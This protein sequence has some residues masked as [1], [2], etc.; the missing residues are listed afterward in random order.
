MSWGN[1]KTA[2]SLGIV[3]LA[4]MM[5]SVYVAFIAEEGNPLAERGYAK[6]AFDNAGNLRVG[7]QVRINQ[8]QVGRVDAIDLDGDRA[9]VTMQLGDGHQIYANGTAAI[10][11]RSGLGQEYVDVRPGDPSAGELGVDGVLPVERTQSST[12]LL[13]LAT[14]L[15]EPTRKAAKS[16]LR[17]LG[18]GA[19]DHGKDLQD[20]LSGAPEMLDDLGTVT[21]SLAANNGADFTATL[22]SLDRLASRFEGR[23]SKLSALVGQ[24]SSTF[25]ALAVDNGDALRASVHAAPGTER[26]LRRALADLDKPLAD[27]ESAMHALAAGSRSL[28]TATPDLRAVLR[29][30]AGPLR[31]VERFSKS[32]QPA[33]RDLA[34]VVADARPIAPKLTKALDSAQTP[35]TVMAPYAA[36]IAK[37]FS[38]ATNALRDGDTAGHWLRFTIIPATDSL[39][40]NAPLTDPLTNSDPYPEPGEAPTQKA[41]EGPLGALPNPMGG[42]T[43]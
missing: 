36:E 40:G 23:N 35:L 28:G 5:V 34:A 4:I 18:S 29:E 3:V 15:D 22:S 17:E 14:E 41:P 27:T 24:L 39:T 11:A 37:W 10:V 31:K 1:R 25:D 2:A 12:Q 20:L 30:S 21:S 6:A 26:A 9:V 42:G 43:R 33:V 7:N 16:A 8:R 13:D 32:A 38:H 19:A